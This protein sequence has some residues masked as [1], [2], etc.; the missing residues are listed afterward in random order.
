MI[1]YSFSNCHSIF[2]RYIML[3]QV[4]IGKNKIFEIFDIICFV[5][6]FWSYTILDN[7]LKRN[8]KDMRDDD[9]PKEVKMTNISLW[10]SSHDRYGAFDEFFIELYF[11]TT[12]LFLDQN[13]DILM[14][15]GKSTEMWRKALSNFYQ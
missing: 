14:M 15:I 12:L 1:Q 10:S 6:M 5:K 13:Q 8:F 3:L 7:M 4:L 9:A 11:Q 2:L